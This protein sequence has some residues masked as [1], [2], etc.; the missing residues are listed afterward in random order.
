MKLRMFDNPDEMFHSAAELLA[1][2]AR[3]A[4]ETRGEFVLALSGG[5]TPIG[6]FDIL[7]ADHAS[8]GSLAVPWEKTVVFQVDERAVPPDHEWNNFKTLSER[9]LSKVPVKE[10][11]THRMVGEPSPEEAAER[12]ESALREFRG[13][14]AESAPLFDFV[15]LGM[16]M[17]GHT[18]S[19][20]PGSEAENERRRL[21]VATPAP[22]TAEPRVPRI[23]LTYPALNDSFKAVFLLLGEDKVALGLDLVLEGNAPPLPS[24][25]ISS[26]E[27]VEWFMSKGISGRD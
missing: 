8:G 13:K 16:G 25:K 19:I 12:Y 2:I 18:A 24:E 11:N 22:A 21:V 7:A 23:T 5:N 14:R 3:K 4:V 17:D 6:L 27:D 26:R 9:L 10:E 15:L 20:F 1:E